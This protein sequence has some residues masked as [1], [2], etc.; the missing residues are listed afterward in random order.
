MVAEI[1]N[2]NQESLDNSALTME[3]FPD[4]DGAEKIKRCP[5]FMKLEKKPIWLLFFQ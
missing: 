5:C 2:D 4:P 3:V 1:E